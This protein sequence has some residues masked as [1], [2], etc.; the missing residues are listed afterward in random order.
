LI[1]C[2]LRADR[3]VSTG[4]AVAVIDLLQAA[5]KRKRIGMETLACWAEKAVAGRVV[6][7]L[8]FTE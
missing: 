3:A 1:A 6:G 7:E 2:A 5:H 8:I 4:L